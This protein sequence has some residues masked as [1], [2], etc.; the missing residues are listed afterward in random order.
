MN[1]AYPLFLLMGFGL[2]GLLVLTFKAYGALD[3]ITNL[4]EIFRQMKNIFKLPRILAKRNRLEMVKIAFEFGDEAQKKWAQEVL[5]VY[6]ED[7]DE[8]DDT[9]DLD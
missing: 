3:A 8:G 2:L 6:I 9:D 4:P 5:Q 7:D 1:I